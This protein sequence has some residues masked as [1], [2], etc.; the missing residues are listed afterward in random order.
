MEANVISVTSLREGD[1]FK[2]LEVNSYGA[3]SIF[4]GIVVDLFNT[5]ESAY[6]Q[7]LQYKKSYEDITAELKVY[8]GDKDLAIFPATIE[9]VQKYFSESIKKLEKDIEEKKEAIQKQI[10][11]LAKARKFV[12]GELSKNM[13]ELSYKEMT[14]K[15][16]QTNKAIKAEKLKELE[17]EE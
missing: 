7:V 14:Q 3:D 4:Y 12:S 13:N 10:E 8:S 15:E 6:I 1:V 17:G 2:L 16:Y 9:E 5:G 11:G